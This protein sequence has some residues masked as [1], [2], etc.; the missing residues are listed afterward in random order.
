MKK[1]EHSL[2]EHGAAQQRIVG[3]A[4]TDARNLHD[5]LGDRFLLVGELIHRQLRKAWLFAHGTGSCRYD[6]NRAGR[7]REHGRNDEGR[8]SHGFP[9]APQTKFCEC[10]RPRKCV[11][12]C[13]KQRHDPVILLPGYLILAQ[14]RG[15]SWPCAETPKPPLP[16]ARCRLLALPSRASRPTSCQL[17]GALLPRLLIAGAAVRDPKRTC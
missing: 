13:H 12:R 10:I 5:L 14:L 16:H 8:A 3:A 2:P 4:D 9:P 17:R 15:Q 6:C 11:P 7:Q 1:I